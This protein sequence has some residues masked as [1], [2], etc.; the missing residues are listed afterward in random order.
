VHIVADGVPLRA[1]PMRNPWGTFLVFLLLAI[2]VVITVTLQ[3]S[4]RSEFV[5]NLNGGVVEQPVEP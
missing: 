4:F 1:G 3:D 5:Q 2:V